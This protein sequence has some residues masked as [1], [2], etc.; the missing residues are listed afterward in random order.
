MSANGPRPSILHL[1]GDYPDPIDPAKTPAVARFLDL[2]RI[3]FDHRVVSINR[4]DPGAGGWLRQLAG[5]GPAIAA[6]GFDAGVALAYEAP[7]KGAFHVSNLLALGDW[8]ADHARRQGWRPDL[9]VGHKL[10]IEGIAIA[11]TAERLGL[12]YALTVQ[13]NT[14]TRI[15]ATR[16]DLHRRLARI[17]HGAATVTCLAPWALA[18]VERHLGK[19]SGPV[20]VVPCATE[21]DLPLPP[22]V[23]GD[24]LV[25]VFHLRQHR[26]KNVEGLARAMAMVDGEATLTIIGGGDGDDR[27][28]VRAL[29]G[30]AANIALAGHVPAEQLRAR[31]NAAKGFVLPSRRES[32]GLVFIEA[33]F[34]GLPIVYP[35]GAA[36]DGYFDFLPFA[37]RIDARDP[38]AIAAA[39]RHLLAEEASLKAALA[40]WQGSEDARRFTRPAIADA[41]AA[42]LRAGLPGSLAGQA[43]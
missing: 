37:V 1:T 16:P 33:L 7:G 43:A 8:L 38:A 11:R 35:A 41:Y 12:P 24:G 2:T 6:Q 39:M 36:V 5:G 19:R 27:Q 22:R 14:D 3:H 40:E 10:G 31:M 29:I 4:R 20:A 13:G 23:G 34:A 15:L 21:L 17:W 26:A 32:F 25:S 28:R 42:S 18:A 9:L 30:N